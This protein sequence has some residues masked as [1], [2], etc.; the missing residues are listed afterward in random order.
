MQYL[1]FI[2]FMLIIA[3]VGLSFARILPAMLG[4]VVTVLGVL[5]G[6]GFAVNE[7]F[8]E[9]SNVWLALLVALPS[10]VAIPMMVNDLQY[11][12]INDVST[13]L[14][15]PPEFVTACRNAANKGR[16]MSFPEKNGLIIR[17]SYKNVRPLYSD[18]SSAQVF[19]IVETLARIQPGWVVTRT[20]IS[21]LRI[22]VEVTSSI[23]K[24]VDDVI[25]SIS[26]QAEQTR[27]DMR[28]KSRD[29]L[30]DA[31][32]NAKRIERFLKELENFSSTSV[33]GG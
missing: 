30:V 18:E 7:V 19:G 29:G 6:L 14:E 21:A 17:Q 20:D 4:W 1:A 27:I 28:S 5:I 32:A 26:A 11:P 31:G 33:L 22:E 25:I 8:S 15:D 2:P 13:N 16:D 23:F 9:N 12:K 24:F 10:M 3:G